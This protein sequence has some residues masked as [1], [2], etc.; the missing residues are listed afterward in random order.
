LTIV[1]ASRADDA[2]PTVLIGS[3][4]EPMQTGKFAPTWESL[5][6]YQA[7]GATAGLSSSAGGQ[8]HLYFRT[9]T[10]EHIF[11]LLSIDLSYIN[12]SLYIDKYINTS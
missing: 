9:A 3:D 1:A 2:K 7:Q 5:Q 10:S 12:S 6:Q 11:P 8:T 4:A